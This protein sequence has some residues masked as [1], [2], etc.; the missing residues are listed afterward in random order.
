MPSSP[1]IAGHTEGAA[2][3]SLEA[4]LAERRTG[5][6]DQ[7]WWEAR[8]PILERLIDPG[9]VSRSRAASGQAAGEAHN[10]AYAPEHTFWFGLQRILDGIEALVRGRASDDLGQI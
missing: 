8:A 1:L 4:A 9:R 5:Q 3:R 6:S 2:R 10:A 7:A